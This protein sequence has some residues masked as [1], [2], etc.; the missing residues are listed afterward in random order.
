MKKLFFTLVSLALFAGCDCNRGAPEMDSKRA[1]EMAIRI[2]EDY[3][4]PNVDRLLSVEWEETEKSSNKLGQIEI[5][6]VNRLG[7]RFSKSFDIVGT[8]VIGN[9]AVPAMDTTTYDFNAVRSL[10]MADLDPKSVLGFVNDCKKGGSE[11]YEFQ[12]VMSFKRLMLIDLWEVGNITNVVF[13][14]KNGNVER[15][16]FMR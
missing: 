13:A 6:I 16:T 14:D 2:V 10:T 1:V 7:K 15:K 5:E 3:I 8:E 12:S 11:G 9:E 4:D